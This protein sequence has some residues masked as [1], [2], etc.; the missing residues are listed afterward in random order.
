MQSL[1]YNLKKTPREIPSW[2]I[3]LT[4]THLNISYQPACHLQGRSQTEMVTEACDRRR[5]EQLGG[6]EI[7]TLGNAIS[8]VLRGICNIFFLLKL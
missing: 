3:L 2:N 7:Q 8:S 1:G 4:I 6:F 5:R